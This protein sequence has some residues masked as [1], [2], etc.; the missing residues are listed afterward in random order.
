MFAG[1]G[2]GMKA[3]EPTEPTMLIKTCIGVGI[4]G[5]SSARNRPAVA[6]G[7]FCEFKAEGDDGRRLLLQPQAPTTQAMT[8]AGNASFVRISRRKSKV[9]ARRKL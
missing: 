7:M 6:D 4:T 2:F 5:S 9:N 1:V 8:S 3:F